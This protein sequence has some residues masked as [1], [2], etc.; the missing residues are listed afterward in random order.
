MTQ[1]ETLTPEENKLRSALA[2]LGFLEINTGVFRG[3]LQKIEAGTK[4]G[5]GNG[6]LDRL[7]NKPHNTVQQIKQGLQAAQTMGMKQ[8]E[9]SS[10]LDNFQ[11]AA[12]TFVE[13]YDSPDYGF[14]PGTE[15]AALQKQFDQQ[16]TG[17]KA[18]NDELSN[19]SIDDILKEDFS[20]TSAPARETEIIDKS[21]EN[22]VL[23]FGAK[24]TSFGERLKNAFKRKKT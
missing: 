17:L 4:G 7:C 12:K 20:I 9:L 10:L 21:G 6:E 22:L 8:K 11:T 24:K 3:A 5:I 1:D 14:Q 18:F 2:F 19:L 13:E 23:D 15:S 16:L